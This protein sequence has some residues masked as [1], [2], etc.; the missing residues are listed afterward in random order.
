MSYNS[1]MPRVR[2]LLLLFGLILSVALVIGN[3]VHA[4]VEHDHGHAHGAESSMWQTLHS[5]LR[6]DD[7][8]ILP[9]IDLL[10]IVGIALCVSALIVPSRSVRTVDSRLQ[11]LRRGIVPYRKFG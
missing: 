8:Q 3:P 9:A 10:A 4:I 5:S 7:K 6:H 11:S 2:T 1:D